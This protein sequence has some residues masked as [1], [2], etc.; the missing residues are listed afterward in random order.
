MYCAKHA[1]DYIL[2]K[3]VRER[4]PSEMGDVVT[5]VHGR[6]QPG[7]TSIDGALRRTTVPMI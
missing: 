3:T 2:G 6:L 5:G 4:A 7:R 1:N